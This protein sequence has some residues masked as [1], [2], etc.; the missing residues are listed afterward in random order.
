MDIMEKKQ[1]KRAPDSSA[2]G[3]MQSG[4]NDRPQTVDG[5]SEKEAN[6]NHLENPHLPIST[7]KDEETHYSPKQ[8]ELIS[9]LR[10]E[11][12]KLERSVRKKIAT[13]RNNE[14][15]TAEVI[16]ETKKL[17][18]SK[19]KK[20]INKKIEELRLLH[21]KIEQGELSIEK[22][23]KSIEKRNVVIDELKRKI[24]S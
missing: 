17:L 19:E 6:K 13:A 18:K 1:P 10:K 2:K 15:L 9:E 8:K 24:A 11:V 20:D 16:L 4:E 12:S 23:R 22:A 21:L 5:H 3:N 7:A 14:R